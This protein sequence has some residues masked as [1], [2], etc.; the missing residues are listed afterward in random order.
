MK[1]P[2]P[3]DRSTATA[4]PG[5]GFEAALHWQAQTFIANRD[6]IIVTD[7]QGRILDWNPAAERTVVHT[8]IRA[9]RCSANTQPVAVRVNAHKYMARVVVHGPSP[10]LT[11]EQRTRLFER[12]YR[13]QGIEQQSGSGV[14]LGLGLH[15]CQTMVARHG[16]QVGVESV[17]GEG[18]T[19][20]FT[21]PPA[22]SAEE[23][24]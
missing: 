17:P 15:I 7:P 9:R 1:V 13:V 5:I 10:G 23:Q 20:W 16:G 24:A 22:S 21:L 2:D 14:G 8:R 18:S 19:F 12:F 4:M 11:P 6:A 3:S